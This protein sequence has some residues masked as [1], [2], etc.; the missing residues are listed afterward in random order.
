MYPSIAVFFLVGTI[1]LLIATVASGRPRPAMFRALAWSATASLASTFAWEVTSEIPPL[2]GEAGAAPALQIA[3]YGFVA[4]ALWIWSDTYAS[5]LEHKQYMERWRQEIDEESH[6]ID[7]RESRLEAMERVGLEAEARL[8]HQKQTLYKRKMQQLRDEQEQRRQEAEDNYNKAWKE[9]R[10]QLNHAK[11]TI[12]DEAKYRKLDRVK[13]EI[14]AC[15]KDYGVLLTDLRYDKDGDR[16][17]IKPKKGDHCLPSEFQE[18]A[19]P[20]NDDVREIYNHYDP[21]RQTLK[22]AKQ[23]TE[24]LRWEFTNIIP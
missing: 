6:R 2:S 4:L 15:A 12:P 10:E 1:A 22:G 3:I 5:D 18:R 24:A 21:I 14:A 20:T 16:V 17:I 23:A 13:K 7:Q 9:M 19:T 11:T 8:E